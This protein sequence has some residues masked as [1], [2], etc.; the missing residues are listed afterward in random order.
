MR[1]FI[2]REAL[3]PHLK[4]AGAMFNSKLPMRTRLVAAAKA[5]LF[6]ARWY[7]RLL[8]PRRSNLE[9]RTSKVRKQFR[10]HLRF[11]EGHSRKLA[12][13][14]F[15]AMVLFGPKLERQQLTLGRFVDIATELFAMTATC[16]RASALNDDEVIRLADY[17]CCM[18]KFRVANLFRELHLNEDRHGYKLAQ[19][20]LK[21]MVLP[22]IDESTH[23]GAVAT[24]PATSLPTA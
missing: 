13:H 15:H 1:L 12:R 8:V 22:P 24:A 14:L 4:I 23:R 3:D 16:A 18:A 9:E 20:L 6:Y 7:P 10:G 2:A 17:F 21:D 5:A 19:T 11:I